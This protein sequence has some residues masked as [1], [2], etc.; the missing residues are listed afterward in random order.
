MRTSLG[1]K[2]HWPGQGNGFV[3]TV[4]GATPLAVRTGFIRTLSRKERSSQGAARAELRWRK[5]RMISD[6][7]KNPF[8]SLGWRRRS[9]SKP[10]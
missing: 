9:S 5:P 8:P 7:E 2:M 1:Q 10:A 6:F 3:S 4:T